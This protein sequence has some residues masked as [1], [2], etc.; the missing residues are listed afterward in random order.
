MPRITDRVFT[1]LAIWM[2]AFGLVIGLVFPPFC[3]LLGLPADQVLS[4]LFYASTILAGLTVGAVNY[5]LARAVV[6][7][8]L[9]QLATH[10]T[11]VQ[12]Q[13]ARATTTDDWSGCDPLECAL[14]VDSAD[15]VGASAAAFNSLI[16]TLAHSH[17]IE[18]AT[19]DFTEVVA[20]HL[21]LESLGRESLT[22]ILRE[23][24]ATAGLL[25]VEREDGL[26]PLS[27]VGISDPE[28][29]A[30]NSQVADALRTGNIVL[31]DV[32][33]EQVVI[34]SVLLEQ[35]AV[36][37]AIVPLAFKAVPLGALVLASVQP[38]AA[39]VDVL[40]R[41]FRTDLGLAL[42]NALSHDRLQR[43]AALD[44]LTD[45]YNRRF[46]MVRLQEEFGRALRV[47][48]PLGVLM[49]D[50]D[51]FKAV[52]DTYGHLVGDRVLRAVAAS[53]RRVSREGDV[54]M[55][56]GGEEFL[57]VVPGAALTDLSELAE[58]IRR[59]VA[60]TEV[61]DGDRRVSVTAS[62]GGAAYPEHDAASATELV[63][64]ADKSLY[65]SKE[66]GRDRITLA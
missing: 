35:A 52:N 50:L 47:S 45:A 57:M 39:V 66:M 64:S 31:L 16:N 27:S 37:V 54:L 40:I 6:G 61:M 12:S 38:F 7:A 1:D 3:L 28:L 4:P 17:R 55:R 65:T 62:I 13:L 10:M 26:Q 53:I 20:S 11:K 19:R 46:G 56:Y 30:A 41:H 24:R 51:H 9:K 58:R 59:A 49:L 2:S 60:A 33:K 34:D 15:E 8:R 18:T 43:L 23:T 29:V 21:D 63:E 22:A 32:N 44:P 36:Q 42:S 48:A 14:P 5:A 25:L